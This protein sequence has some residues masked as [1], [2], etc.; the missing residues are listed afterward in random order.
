MEDVASAAGVSVSTVSRVVRDKGEVSPETRAKIEDVIAKLGFRPSFLARAL[1]AGATRTIALLVSDLDDPFYPRLAKAIGQE[2]LNHGLGVVVCNTDDQTAES[3]DFVE[4]LHDRV[5]G[6]IHASVGLDENEV[7]AALGASHRIVFT[8]RRPASV[9]VSYVVSDNRAGSIALTN[10]LIGLG[11]RRI[12]FISGP[13]WASNSQDR[14]AGFAAAMTAAQLQPI[15]SEGAF[16]VD[17][18]ARAVQRWIMDGNLPSAIIGANDMIA[19]EAWAALRESN[20]A[21]PG[22]IAIAGFD[23]TPIARSPL[24]AM[25]S[26]AQP[27]EEMARRAVRLLVDQLAGSSQAPVQ[28]VLEPT[29]IARASTSTR[30]EA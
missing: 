18:G 14:L 3:V 22:D 7:L 16:G 25:T 6:V 10:H 19:L 13:E 11:H 21:V 17:S 24:I 12:G 5:D 9:V 15:H 4:R 29:L 1:V 20:V 30:R 8:N 27:I 23:D 28:V 2:A 26:V